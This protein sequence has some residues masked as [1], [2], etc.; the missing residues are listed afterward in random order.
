MYL[1]TPWLHKDKDACFSELSAGVSDRKSSFPIKTCLSRIGCKKG[2]DGFK[3]LP[4]GIRTGKHYAMLISKDNQAIRER[5]FEFD[6]KIEEMHLNF[7]KYC[8]GI[9]PKRPDCEMME[10]ELLGFSRRKIYDLELSKQLDRV[11][12]KFQNRKKIWLR[13]AE[14]FQRGVPHE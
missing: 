1:A 4:K 11:L 6:R 13:W 10:R 9:E 2:Q 5:I 7:Q 14:E 12:F 8:Q 3:I